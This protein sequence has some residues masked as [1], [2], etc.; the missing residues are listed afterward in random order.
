MTTITTEKSLITLINVFTVSPDNQQRLV[1]LLVEATQHTM[2][3]QP[4]YI[5]ANIHKSL[6]G[7]RVTNYAQWRSQEDF[8]AI[9][10]NPEVLVH[11]RAASQLATS[12]EPHLYEVSFIDALFSSENDGS[13]FERK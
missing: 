2:R 3:N 13:D 9:E 12:I 10:K 7:T 5:S 4:G 1:D 8:E 6:D 11:M